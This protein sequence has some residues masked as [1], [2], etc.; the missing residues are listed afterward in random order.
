M[1]GKC[2]ENCFRKSIPEGVFFYRF[3]DGTSSWDNGSN[4]RFQ[5]FNIAD[6]ELFYNN[7]LFI[8]ELKTT[9]GKS[10]PYKNIRKS[11]IEELT[12]ASMYKNIICGLVIDFSE[13][14]ECYFIKIN[15]F[16]E[17]IN[18]SERASIPIDYLRNNAVKVGVRLLRTNKR[19]NVSD[20]LEVE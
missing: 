14:N 16:N 12:K 4:T 6:C 15:Q 5:A 13:L 1:T 19:Y 8:L 3:R 10:L 7:K 9:K 11:Q 20:I 17:F 2:Y 18:T